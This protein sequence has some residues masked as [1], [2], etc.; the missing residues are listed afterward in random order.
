MAR[1]RWDIFAVL[2]FLVAGPVFEGEAV[3]QSEARLREQSGEFFGEWRNVNPRARIV[4]RI[5]VSPASGDNVKVHVWGDCDGRECD[6]GVERAAVFEGGPQAQGEPRT[7][8]HVKFELDVNISHLIL[9]RNPRDGG[10]VVQVFSRD[11]GGQQRSPDEIRPVGGDNTY[12]IERFRRSGSAE[13]YA[14]GERRDEGRRW[15]E[16]PAYASDGRDEDWRRQ[17]ERPRGDYAEPDVRDGYGRERDSDWRRQEGREAC[18]S[19]D[20][21]RVDLSRS[22]G[23]WKIAEGRRWL[24]DF[25]P[26]RDDAEHALEVIHYYHLDQTCYV[27]P[28]DSQFAYL[29]RGGQAPSGN[30]ESEDCDRFNADRLDVRRVEGRF[31]IVDGDRWLYDFG[32]RRDEAEQ[33]L[34][35]IQKHGFRAACYVG[36]SEA[37]FRYF[38]R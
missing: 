23:R 16:R 30:L 4:R 1:W 34:E 13:K 36:R 21:E 33:A 28:R 37:N 2:G 17:S 3:A 8:V 29:L 35:I 20:P 14:G 6:W 7:A 26:S 12:S 32:S 27:G 38:R 22:E 25:G 18:V 9:M 5:V 24:F 15:D 11:Q 19:F 10:L 31:R